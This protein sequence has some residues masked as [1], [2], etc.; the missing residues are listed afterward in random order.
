MQR[1]YVRKL[2]RNSGNKIWQQHKLT[3]FEHFKNLFKHLWC[4]LLIFSM[5]FNT[6]IFFN[7]EILAKVKN[8]GFVQNKEWIRLIQPWWL[9]GNLQRCNRSKKNHR[10][11]IVISQIFLHQKGTKTINNCNIIGLNRMGPLKHQIEIFSGRSTKN[12]IEKKL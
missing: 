1:K 12:C 11:I 2:T 7:R 6:Y 10:N 5:I 8:F 4:I 9:G 3:F